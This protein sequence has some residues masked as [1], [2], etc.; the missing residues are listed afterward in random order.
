MEFKTNFKE[1]YHNSMSGLIS[2]PIYYA[3]ASIIEIIIV[4]LILYK[5]NPWKVSEKYPVLSI[6]FVLF[7]LFVQILTY[8]FV[9]NKD[10]L[11][12]K[13]ISIKPNI[14]DFFIKVLF[15][16]ATLGI[17]VFGLY[18]CIHLLTS[19]PTLHTIFRWSINTIIIIVA[20]SILY[21]AL[22]P[23][24]DASKTKDGKATI[25]TLI[26]NLILY[27]PCLVIDIVEWFKYQYGITTRPVLIL[28]G[29]QGIFL[30]L[31]FLL[32]KLINWIQYQNA[33]QLLMK[34]VSL[35]SEHDVGSYEEIYKGNDKK[36]HYSLSALFWLNPQPP[37]TRKSYT[38]FTNILTFGDRPAIEF[39]AL[40]NMLRVRCKDEIIYETRE[41]QYQKWNKIVINY[42][43]ANMDVFIN[44]RLVAS[45]PNIVPFMSNENI[46]VGEKKG[47]EGGIKNVLLGDFA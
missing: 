9:E 15:T 3:L 37:N 29:M 46:K 38:K 1:M 18:L 27:I 43:G 6:L 28:L 35:N 21:L 40:E 36:Y 26:S 12:K 14:Y 20:I 25:I 32:P 30:T 2:N 31:R 24:I 47:L 23:V 42:D 8:L 44:K 5:W 45:K 7:I 39:N 33:K 41:I 34:P 22:K 11:R 4:G 10:I 17:I 16:L 19:F 13:G